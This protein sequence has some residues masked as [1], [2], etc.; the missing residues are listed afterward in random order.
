MR[1]ATAFKVY[2]TNPIMKARRSNSKN[3]KFV[4]IDNSTWIETNK[5]IPDEVARLQ[6]LQKMQLIK[7]GTFM[8]QV[9]TDDL[10]VTG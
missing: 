8:G 6:F 9:K 7:P 4:R 1:A 5:W 10:I 3:T 2:K